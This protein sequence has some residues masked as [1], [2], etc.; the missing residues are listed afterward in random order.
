MSR[1]YVSYATFKER[2]FSYVGTFKRHQHYFQCW[3]ITLGRE[4]FYLYRTFTSS[5]WIYEEHEMMTSKISLKFSS[6]SPNLND[7]NRICFVPEAF[8]R[9]QTFLSL[10]SEQKDGWDSFL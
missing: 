2:Q 1:K 9:Y 3:K 10:S 7:G 4:L 5:I 6:F 8:F